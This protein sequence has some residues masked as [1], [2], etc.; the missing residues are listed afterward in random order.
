TNGMSLSKRN[1]RH[2]N[3]G[4]VV[5]IEPADL[6]GAGF[7]GT[8]GGLRFQRQLEVRAFEAGGGKLQAPAT[9]ATDFVAG[10][11]SSSVPDSS[12]LP[13]LTPSNVRDVLDAGGL[14]LAER[15]ATALGE[16]DRRMRGYLTEEAVLVG[17]ESRSS[18]PVRVVRDDESLESPSL[19]GLYPCGEG[20]GYAGGIVSAA[21]DGARVAE[22]I[23]KKWG[24]AS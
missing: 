11:A 17:V 23:S 18:S 19:A 10:R 7:T 21:V 15:L 16:F 22:V 24:K 5:S 12:Y 6:E 20:A 13:G 3:S 4:L 9:R 1:S 8:L 2:A 14:P